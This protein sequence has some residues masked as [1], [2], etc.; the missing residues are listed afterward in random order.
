MS[1]PQESSGSRLLRKGRK[2]WL[3]LTQLI[4]GNPDGLLRVMAE[5]LVPRLERHRNRAWADR[6]RILLLRR[7]PGVRAPRRQ[8]EALLASTRLLVPPHW[9]PTL[10]ERRRLQRRLSTRMACTGAAMVTCDDWVRLPTGG[11]TWRQKPLWDSPFDAEVEIAEGPVLVRQGC[12]EEIG[13]LPGAPHGP[14]WREALHRRAKGLGGHAHL[15]LPLVR[16]PV[17]AQWNAP[18]APKDQRPQQEPLVSVLIPTAGSRRSIRGRPQVLVHNCIRS[19]MQRSR[20][21]HLEVVIIDGGECSDELIEELQT[22]VSEGLGAERW[23]FLRERRPYCYTS[24]INRAAEAAHGELLLQLNDDTEMLDPGAVEALIEALRGPDVGIAGALLLYP[25]GKVQHAG[26]AID[27]LAPRHAWAG[28][29]PTALPWGTLQGHRTFHAVT[30][31][32][33]LCRRDLWERLGGCSDRF[34]VNYGDVDFC[35]RAA[36]LGYRTV[37]EPRS[38][39]LHYESA[40]RTIEQVPPE[41]RTFEETWSERLGGKYNVDEYCSAWRLLLGEPAHD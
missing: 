16:A 28:C 2:G 18:V 31:A 35:L 34:P 30:A 13:A 6:L 21:R 8:V 27:N 37:L 38:R 10:L 7:Q 33:S 1:A 36:D 40:S 26:T 11:W 5:R 4:R 15:P 39:W 32:V 24:R 29:Q 19:L 20:Y 41:L 22:M 14:A 25:D 17:P 12:L 3:I 9:Q 23:Q